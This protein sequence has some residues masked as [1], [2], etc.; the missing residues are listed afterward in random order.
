MP[1]QRSPRTGSKHLMS[2]GKRTIPTLNAATRQSTSC[3][4]PLCTSLAVF[5]H[6]SVEIFALK[7]CVTL[8]L[9]S[10]LTDTDLENTGPCRPS[11]AALPAPAAGRASSA[12]RPRRCARRRP[13]TR[14]DHRTGPDAPRRAAAGARRPPC[15]GCIFYEI[16]TPRVYT[17][18]LHLH[19]TDSIAIGY[20]YYCTLY[21]SY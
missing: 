11:L 9:A 16:Y 14:R 4:R 21:L 18:V 2:R 10:F 12:A 20:S 3:N 5:Q 6:Y 15:G 1:R 7:S 8:T 19:V 13:S 17:T